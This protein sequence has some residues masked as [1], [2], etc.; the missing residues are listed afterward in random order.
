MEQSSYDK[1]ESS[2][3]HFTDLQVTN[4]INASGTLNLGFATQPQDEM[5]FVETL[6]NVACPCTDKCSSDA[7][8]KFIKKIDGPAIKDKDF[9]TYWEKGNEPE[10]N[11]CVD[12]CGDRAVSIN[13]IK[14]ASELVATL[15]VYKRTLNIKPKGKTKYI[16]FTI[17][18]G[19]GLHKSTPSVENPT[20]YDFYKADGFTVSGLSI[21]ST[22]PIV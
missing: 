14:N 3:P 10:T 6:A 22:N 18:K 5:T 20:H 12:I 7:D 17:P 1:S 15:E 21:I 13:C 16:L 9:L 11:E 4:G 8:I 2:G 19:N